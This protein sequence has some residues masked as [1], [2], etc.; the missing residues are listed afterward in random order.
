MACQ[1]TQFHGYVK[2]FDPAMKR[3][4]YLTPEAY[5]ALDQS[6]P[7]AQD[8][9][10]EAAHIIFGWRGDLIK[11]TMPIGELVAEYMALKNGGAAKPAVPAGVK[12]ALAALN[13]A[14]AAVG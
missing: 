1:V 13:A 9:L 8:R 5:K 11:C 4:H 2:V 14:V 6:H 10:A 7:G 12:A 3:T